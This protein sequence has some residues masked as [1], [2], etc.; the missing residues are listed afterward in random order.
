MSD[1]KWEALYGADTSRFPDDDEPMPT[2][3]AELY[4]W[5]CGGSLSDRERAA[6]N[7]DDPDSHLCMT[8]AGV[9][10]DW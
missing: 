4:C 3:S 2:Q 8:C 9:A 7:P 5:R 10:E 6:A 1:W